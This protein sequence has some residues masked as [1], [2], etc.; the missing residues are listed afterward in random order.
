MMHRYYLS[1]LQVLTKRFKIRPSMSRPMLMVVWVKRGLKSI[2]KLSL[3][4]LL[5][6][7]NFDVNKPICFLQ[8]YYIPAISLKQL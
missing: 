4:L 7:F 1:G 6:Y 8:E 2:G 5:P 3:T